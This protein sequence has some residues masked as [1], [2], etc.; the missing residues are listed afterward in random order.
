MNDA[1]LVVGVD[2]GTSAAKVLA[3]TQTG[4]IVAHAS[5]SYAL[6][7]PEP[8]AVE[9]DPYE[10]EHAARTALRSVLADARGRGHVRAVGFSCAMHGFVPVD[11]RGEPVG[12]FITWMDRRSSAVADRWRADGTAQQLYER[13]GAPVHPMLPSCKLRWF[14]ERDPAYVARASRF[15]SLKELLVNRFTGEWLVDYGMA[16]GTGLYDLRARTWDRAA[17]DAA[18][19][20]P[21]KLSTLASTRTSLPLRD[22]VAATLG[23]ANDTAIVLASSDG[24]LANL[25]VGAVE[26]GEFA[27]TIGTSGALRVVVDEPQLDSAGRTFCYAYDDERYIAG[28]A[29]S[30][31]GAVL[32]R[33]ATL[34]FGDA[35]P[36]E[37]MQRA[38]ADA[39]QAPPGANGVTV[40]P[41]LSGERAPYWRSGLRGAIGNLELGSTRPDVLRAA[42]ESVAYALAS[43]YAV[44][45]E[46]LDP[47]RRLRLSG[48]L[49]HDPFVRQLFAD[50]FGIATTLTDQEE[51]SAFGAAMTA[52]L[53]IGLLPNDAA[54]AALLRPQ[55]Q[56]APSAQTSDAYAEAFERYT[57]AA[58]RM[59]KE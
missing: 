36:A 40:L 59:L 29:T 14:A 31:A 13:T 21:E 47:P 42:F 53:A 6:Q 12:A 48:G 54:V 58:A 23:L 4:E 24:A 9:L 51:A 45:R 56:H 27:L 22:G 49:A 55:Y 38:L 26:A 41:F 20:A 39:A 43:V 35:P 57:A 2:L 28:G 5:Q 7:T 52:A 44:L 18:G 34:F 25:G 17:L 3:A 1:E 8:D 30:S 16:S 50:V 10:V 15:V 19:I 32:A 11:E 37:R 33:F 46:R